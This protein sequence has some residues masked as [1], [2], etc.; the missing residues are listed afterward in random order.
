MPRGAV[1]AVMD[2]NF[3]Q[4]MF[5]ASRLPPGASL[6]LLDHHGVRIF[7]RPS[8]EYVGKAVSSEFWEKAQQTPEGACFVATGADGVQRLF[9]VRAVRLTPE[10]SPYLYLALGIPESYAYAKTW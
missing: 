7:S 2:L 4:E 10:A 5:T 6:T 9:G 8:Q 3:Y 1:A